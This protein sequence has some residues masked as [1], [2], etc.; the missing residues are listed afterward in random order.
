MLRASQAA[1]VLPPGVLTPA[2]PTTTQSVRSVCIQCTSPAP[3]LPCSTLPPAPAQ[4][5]A[6]RTPLSP[7]PPIPFYYNGI[8]QC[9]TFKPAMEPA[10]QV[11]PGGEAPGSTKPR[12]SAA[13]F[14]APRRAA[15]VPPPATA[16]PSRPPS[17]A[18]HA[19]SSRCA[20]RRAGLQH[21][22]PRRRRAHARLHLLV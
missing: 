1:A 4:R 9:C 15:T 17:A 19:W 13:D 14:A 21:S 6:R 12:L 5:P 18:S 8:R 10:D 7:P 20:R 2:N 11:S 16:P 3:G 22:G